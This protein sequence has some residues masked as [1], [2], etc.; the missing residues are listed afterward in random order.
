M[1]DQ[2]WMTHVDPYGNISVKELEFFRDQGGF[3]K[4][5]GRTWTPVRAPDPQ[6]ARAFAYL[7]HGT[8]YQ[9]GKIDHSKEAF[10]WAG[11][12]IQ[13]AGFTYRFLSAVMGEAI[14]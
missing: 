6:R 11:K 13:E 5:W 14:K 10:E 7:L 8:P 1:S 4:D 2:I 3:R 12:A 9:P